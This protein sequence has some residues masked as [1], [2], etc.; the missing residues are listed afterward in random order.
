MSIL[1]ID[2]YDSFTYNLKNL[3]ESSISGSIDVKTIYSD[4]LADEGTGYNINDFAEFIISNF[5][6]III[7]PG[8]GNPNKPSD[9]GLIKHLFDEDLFDRIPILGVCLGFQAMCIKAGI[10]VVP[11]NNVKHGQVDIVRLCSHVESALYDGFP[12]QF[13]SVRYHSL[14]GIYPSLESNESQQMIP[15]AYTLDGDENTKILMAGKLRGRPHFG[16]QYHPESIMSENGDTLISNFWENVVI[17]HKLKQQNFT[18]NTDQISNQSSVF[19]TFYVDSSMRLDDQKIRTFHSGASSRKNN[20]SQIYSES[21]I[22]IKKLELGKV[23]LSAIN[24]IDFLKGK[25]DFD[26]DFFLLNSIANPGRFS[27]IGCPIESHSDVITWSLLSDISISKWKSPN[28]LESSSKLKDESIWKFLQNYMSERF[29]LK[30]CKVEQLQLPFVGGLIGYISY[31]SGQ[32]I[33]PDFVKEIYLKNNIESSDRPD[34][35]MIFIERSIILDSLNNDL[36]VVSI[37]PDDQQWIEKTNKLLG[38]FIDEIGMHNFTSTCTTPFT[39]FNVQIKLPEKEKYF[40]AFHKCQKFLRSGDSYELCLCTKTEIQLENKHEPLKRVDPW[41]LYKYLS[42][43]NP[44]PYSGFIKFDDDSILISSSPE[45]FLTWKNRYNGCIP[46][47][48]RLDFDKIC[49]LRPIKG[50]V[51]KS[52]EMTKEK[53]TEILNS[54]KEIGENLMIVDLIR[55]D[56]Y[57]HVQNSRK[58][59]KFGG[60]VT[61]VNVTK[62]MQVEEYKT[63]YQLV[64]VIECTVESQNLDTDSY[65]SSQNSTAFEVFS[66]SLPPGSMTGAPKKKSVEL[67]QQKLENTLDGDEDSTRGIY[68]GVYGYW[69]IDDQ[70]DWS[71][72]IRSMFSYDSGSTWRIGAGGAI[73]VLSDVEG[74]WEEMLTKLDSI[75]QI[76]EK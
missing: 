20:K 11:L 41:K 70:A 37:K 9:I 14:H 44:A 17:P 39:D 61:D 76:F 64:S 69:S 38:Q 47:E 23:E 31:E 56:L 57:S 40:S 66:T 58:N 48:K 26:D 29:I 1:L 43:R 32:F 25:N 54:D 28:K 73:T 55:H 30:S 52:A 6:C 60:I 27:I 68:S 2:S 75:L 71:V 7:G 63:V 3:L 67:L 45:R 51:K 46:D 24:I 74:E 19:E 33:N 42:Y 59:K 72:V 8:P 21:S 62:L 12:L 53:A 49:Q 4:T 5:D 50:T 15:L 65:S 36:Y 10:S 13:N 16:V 22:L 35:K 34:I 18:F